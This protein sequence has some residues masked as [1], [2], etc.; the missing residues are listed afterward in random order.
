MVDTQPG[1]QKDLKVYNMS[2]PGY[3]AIIKV[4][5]RPI[6]AEISKVILRPEAPLIV[7]LDRMNENSEWK[8]IEPIVKAQELRRQHDA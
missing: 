8:F 2:L 7:I 1:R 5:Q 6:S 3:L 4:D